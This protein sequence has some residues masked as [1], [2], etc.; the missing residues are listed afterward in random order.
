MK[1]KI[2][3]KLFNIAIIASI[4]SG[5]YMYN[6]NNNYIKKL[7]FVHLGS[8]IN[9]VKNNKKVN[10]TLIVFKAHQKIQDSINKNYK[11]SKQEMIQF[12]HSVEEFNKIQSKK[13]EEYPIIKKQDTI[14]EN[15]IKTFIIRNY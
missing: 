9:I 3:Y 13:Y 1:I 12:L 4:I 6:H 14:I 7:K 10:N 5:I 15:K 11:P 2:N 8:P